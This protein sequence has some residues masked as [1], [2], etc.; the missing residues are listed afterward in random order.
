MAVKVSGV[1]IGTRKTGT[2]WL[3]ENF[4]KDPRVV[5]SDKVKE[6]GFFTGETSLDAPRYH[7]LFEANDALP[8]LEVDTSVC[9]APDAPDCIEQYN[10]QM[11]VVLI[12]REP[13]SF[14]ASRHTHSLRK[15][16]LKEQGPAE[17]LEANSWLQDELDYPA[18]TERFARFGDQLSVFRYSD[19]KDDP[20]GFYTRVLSA[21][22]VEDDGRFTPETE[23]VN[24]SRNSKLRVVTGFLS[25]SAFAARRIGLHRLVNGL[26]S[27]GLHKKL[28]IHNDEAEKAKSQEQATQAVA[29]LMPNTVRFYEDL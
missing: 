19:M 8:C 4:R 14:L 10:P 21:L 27:F 13:G 15:G 2:T 6:S 9:Y 29:E 24:V 28:E 12:L 3:Y 17:A 16:E 22:G 23:P 5:V 26:K 18:I 7:G 20:V 1:V 25:K 11:R